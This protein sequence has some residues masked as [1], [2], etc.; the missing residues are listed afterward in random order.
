MLNFKGTFS[1]KM[2]NHNAH[3]GVSFDDQDVPTNT[4]IN[5]D[6][7]VSTISHRNFPCACILEMDEAIRAFPWWEL[8]DHGYLYPSPYWYETV[9]KA[10]QKDPKISSLILQLPKFMEEST[11]RDKNATCTICDAPQKC[12]HGFSGPR[13]CSSG[14]TNS[15]ARKPP[16]HRRE[17]QRHVSS[18]YDTTNN[19]G[20]LSSP[21][22]YSGN[23]F[24]KDAPQ[25]CLPSTTIP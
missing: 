22:Y 14:E 16:K 4:L 5:C 19:N 23:N 1:S 21:V 11:A 7:H 13:F 15:S 3:M 24:T 6:L 12:K 10:M 17:G 18:S 9:K 20:H 8:E 2:G 25:K